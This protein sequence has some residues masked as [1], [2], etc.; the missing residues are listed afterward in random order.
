VQLAARVGG[1]ARCA[2]SERGSGSGGDV[3][4][5]CKGGARCRGL[6]AMGAEHRGRLGGAETCCFGEGVGKW[7]STVERSAREIDGAGKKG[8]AHRGD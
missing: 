5:Q 2:T 6:L 7:A 1:G 3:R 4:Q 8:S